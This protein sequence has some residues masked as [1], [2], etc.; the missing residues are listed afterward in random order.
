MKKKGEETTL[1]P[2]WRELVKVL[3]ERGER[4]RLYTHGEFA[5][6]LGVESQSQKYYGLVNKARKALREKGIL[7]ETYT[8][9][10]YYITEANRHT[11]VASEDLHKAN[12]HVEITL[13]GL[14]HAPVKEM[15]EH[16]RKKRDQVLVSTVG[17]KNMFDGTVVEINQYLGPIPKRFQ[18]SES[19]PKLTQE[20]EDDE[21]N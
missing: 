12:R 9:K 10:G 2:I 8:S 19:K 14:R 16:S 4:G 15:D 18:L 7:L 11:E 17:L 5:D 6:I 20:E 3:L 21:D 1:Y 13:I